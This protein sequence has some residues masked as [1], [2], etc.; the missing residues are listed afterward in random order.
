MTTTSS[1]LLA[2]GEH[3]RNAIAGVVIPI[4]YSKYSK[5]PLIQRVFKHL[6][7]GDDEQ[8]LIITSLTSTL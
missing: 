7:I 2:L 1:E 3:Q 5:S 8:V 6:Q 4:I